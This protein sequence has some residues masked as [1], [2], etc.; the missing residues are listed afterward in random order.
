MELLCE[1]CTAM[2]LLQRV[3]LLTHWIGP[4]IWLGLF[5]EYKDKYAGFGKGS[6]PG[7]EDCI[8]SDEMFTE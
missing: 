8:G 2:M 3:N 1:I 6:V 4:G 7:I 5:F